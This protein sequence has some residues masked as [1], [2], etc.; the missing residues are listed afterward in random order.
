MWDRLL[1]YPRPVLVLGGLYAILPF[2]MYFS[3]K[4]LVVWVVLAI[5]ALPPVD[6][7]KGE[8]SLLRMSLLTKAMLALLI[9]TAISL[10]W[11]PVQ[12]SEKI[13]RMTIFLAFGGAFIYSIASLNVQN[14]Q[15]V[16]NVVLVCISLT[17][18]LLLIE[19]LSGLALSRLFTG[20]DLDERMLRAG[21]SVAAIIAISWPLLGVL[22]IGRSKL[23]TVA[24]TIV[25]GIALCAIGL[26]ALQL[27]GFASLLSLTLGGFALLIVNWHPRAGLIIIGIL[28]FGYLIFAPTIHMWPLES[29]LNDDAFPTPL[30][31]EHRFHI[32]NAA[33]ERIFEHPITGLGF[34]AS[35]SLG[36]V[37]LILRGQ[38][39]SAMPLHPHNMFLQI[40]LEL[41]LIG[42][43][44]TGII[45]WAIFKQL[46]LRQRHPLQVGLLSAALV[47]YLIEAMLNFGAWQTWWIATAWITAGTSLFAPRRV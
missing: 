33:A 15:I 13:L 38:R 20:A 19:A 28:V 44:F 30:S 14:R 46:W 3:P 12:A 6:N 5:F 4:G 35:R 2:I 10:I 34:D 1:Q 37:E 23:N 43:T 16:R 11:S 18:A 17:A 9:W 26:A 32:W 39:L 42:V 31:W 41:G 7:W 8:L 36:D 25:A 27:Q 21:R 24:G 29:N 47:S 45:L 22:A 40:W